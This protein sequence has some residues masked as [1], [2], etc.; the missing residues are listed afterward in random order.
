MKPEAKI[1][2]AVGVAVAVYIVYKVLT[3]PANAK[4]NK[5]TNSPGVLPKPV[6]GQNPDLAVPLN[7]V[8]RTAVTNKDGV[9]LRYGAGVTYYSWGLVPG[10]STDSVVSSKGTDVGKIVA[11]S[12]DIDNDYSKSWYKLDKISNSFFHSGNPVFVNT[13]DV[14][15][16]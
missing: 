9:H 11:V 3:A 15:T 5:N 8:G 12:S 10:D 1:I 14:T 13:A 16:I 4:Y 7:N 2:T 6:P